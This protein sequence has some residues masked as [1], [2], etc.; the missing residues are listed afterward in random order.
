[1]L[2]LATRTHYDVLGVSPS[3]TQDD[4]RRAYRALARNLH[5][6]VAASSS[7]APLA[8]SEVNNAW[9]VLSDPVR[10]REY[11]RSLENQSPGDT[12]RGGDER[13]TFFQVPTQVSPARFPWRGA[14]FFVVLGI[15]VVLV[16]AAFVDPEAPPGPDQL[17]TSGSCVDI[18]TTFAVREVDCS[19]SHD[20]V[21]RQL[22]AFD[23]K[24]PNGSE[25]YRDSQGMGTACVD[26]VPEASP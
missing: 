6:D 17:L 14:L 21:V 11:D 9:S 5:P 2:T 3:A 10:R 12:V 15:V 8:M 22:I 20:A 24:C 7:H 26:R 1:M 23:A 25:P 19:G 16:L 4:I 18:D 13:E